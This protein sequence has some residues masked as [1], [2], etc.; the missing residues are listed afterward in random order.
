MGIWCRRFEDRVHIPAAAGLRRFHKL[1]R[2]A[3]VT[4]MMIAPGLTAV[5][6]CTISARIIFAPMKASMTARPWL[7]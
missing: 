3:A 2:T 7:R 6:I 1:R 4:I 5:G